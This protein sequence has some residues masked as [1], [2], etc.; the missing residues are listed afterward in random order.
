MMELF[1]DFDFIEVSKK[2]LKAAKADIHNLA[3]N[4]AAH[5]PVRTPSGVQGR[6]GSRVLRGACEGLFFA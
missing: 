4:T 5:R 1:Q 2:F 3:I 6:L